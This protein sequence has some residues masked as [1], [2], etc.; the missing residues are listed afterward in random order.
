MNLLKKIKE[1]I[2]TSTLAAVI[3]DKLYSVLKKNTTPKNSLESTTGKKIS[4]KKLK[5][6]TKIFEYSSES[7]TETITTSKK[8]N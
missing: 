2:L 7:K 4:I 8:K 3:K 6:N 5:V 1:N